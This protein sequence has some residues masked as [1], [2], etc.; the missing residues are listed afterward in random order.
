MIV[1]RAVT[2]MRPIN[3]WA[4]TAAPSLVGAARVDSAACYAAN[5]SLSVGPADLVIVTGAQR[6]KFE[7]DDRR[8]LRQVLGDDF[9]GLRLLTLP[10]VA[11]D[12]AEVRVLLALGHQDPRRQL[13]RVAADVEWDRRGALAVVQEPPGGLVLDDEIHG[14]SGGYVP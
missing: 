6:Q 4:S 14:V 8:I 1:T 12:D 3:F 13:R 10:L 11:P 9:H 7:G 2:L 5:V